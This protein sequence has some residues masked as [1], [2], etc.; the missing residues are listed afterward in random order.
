VPAVA[1]RN[2][3][4]TALALTV[5][6]RVLKQGVRTLERYARDDARAVAYLSASSCPARTWPTISST[7]ASPSRSGRRCPELGVSLDN[8]IEQ[9]EEPGLGNGGLGRLA[10]CFWIRSR[11]W[12]CPA[13]GYGIRYEFGIFDQTITDGWQVEITDKWL[14]FGNPWRLHDRDRLRR[15]VRRAH[16]G[17]DRRAGPLPCPLGLPIRSSRVWPTTPRFWDTGSAPATRCGSGRPR[18][19]SRSIL[20][21]STKGLL[22][23]G[24]GQDVLREHHQGVVPERPRCSRARRCASSSQFFFVTCSLQDMIRVHGLMGPAA[25]PVPREVGGPA[26]RHPPR[27]PPLRS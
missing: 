24:R 5:R 21:R 10:S 8:L 27:H 3:A 6:D 16:R 14:R 7:S 23:G 19:W 25:R 18:R 4:Y 26:Q 15:P 9:E 1:T 17:L 20:P 11:R 12:T 22:P 13:V 2:D